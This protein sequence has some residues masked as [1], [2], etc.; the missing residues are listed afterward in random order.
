M[1]EFVKDFDVEIYNEIINEVE[2]NIWNERCISIIQSEIEKIIKNL[3]KENNIVITNTDKDGVVYREYNPTLSRLLNEEESFRGFLFENNILKENDIDDYWIIHRN[4][5]IKKHGARTGEKIIINNEM[6]ES[7]LKFLFKLCFN[8]YNYKFHKTPS[9]YWDER[10]FEKL[11]TK[12]EEKTIEVEKIIEKEIKVVDDVELNK[13]KKEHDELKHKFDTMQK[14]TIPHTTNFELVN[15]LEIA[16]K[17]LQNEDFENAKIA[18]NNCR[19]LDISCI[20]AYIGLIMCDYKQNN[21]ENLAYDI[22]FYKNA[23]PLKENENYIN[24]SNFCDKKLVEKFNKDIEETIHYVKFEKPHQK[25]LSEYDNKEYLLAYRDFQFIHEYKDASDKSKELL[26]ILEQDAKKYEKDKWY[27]RAIIEYNSLQFYT[28]EKE[29]RDY[30]E[31]RINEIKENKKS[32]EETLIVNEKFRSFLDSK[33][34][35][36]YGSNRLSKVKTLIIMEGVNDIFENTFREFS[37]LETII[38]PDSLK[39]IHKN[40]FYY[41]CGKL[42]YNIKNGYKYLGSENN[43]YKILI[44]AENFNV[45]LLAETTEIIAD[46]AIISENLKEL[47]IPKSI[48]Y[49]CDEAFELAP[50]IEKVVVNHEMGTL[51]GFSG[52]KKLKKI[53]LNAPVDEIGDYAFLGCDLLN[54]F[55][56]FKNWHISISNG[57]FKNCI[58]LKSIDFSKIDSVYLGK[59]AFSH[60]DNLENIKFNQVGKIDLSD[61]VFEKCINLKNLVFDQ[62]TDFGMACFSD[63]KGLTEVVLNGCFYFRSGN[64]LFSRC[65]NLKRVFINNTNAKDQSIPYDCFEDCVNLEKITVIGS[66]ISIGGGAFENCNNL[67]DIEIQ[68][69]QYIREIGA[70]AFQ[71]CENLKNSLILN[72]IENIE[73]YAFANSGIEKIEI[74][75]NRIKKIDNWAFEECKNLKEFIFPSSSN[76][77]T[78]IESGLFKSCTALENIKI[79][80]YIVEIDSYAFSDCKNLKNIILPN[81]LVEIGHGA[82]E[83]CIALEKIEIPNDIEKLD[84]CCFSGCKNLKEINIPK[85]IRSLNGA[86]F[87]ECINLEQI[88]IPKNVLKIDTYVFKNCLKLKQIIIETDDDYDGAIF[89]LGKIFDITSISGCESLQHL[90]LPGCFSKIVS[91]ST[92]SQFGTYHFQTLIINKKNGYSDGHYKFN[93]PDN[94]YNLY[95]KQNE[96][97]RF[98]FK[99]K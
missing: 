65:E 3:F 48:K 81:K 51:G 53:E 34:F 40:A 63:C 25:A 31:S 70:H 66:I 22:D 27:E 96:D 89:G 67:K 79:P 97:N 64:C 10:Y 38:L 90:E 23:K 32:E 19:T 15:K 42:K 78:K 1:F 61:F 57:A 94:F 68:N 83:N 87:S 60:C 36:S 69:L 93:L 95:E 73:A 26:S 28:K 58:N 29:L 99:R 16:N 35:S 43:P 17:C 52:C 45:S 75:S 7:A 86:L 44:K 59:Y 80:N 13:L 84:D 91:N 54:D 56:A 72:N 21:M 76:K 12:P 92:F 71:N 49:I 11:L 20:D 88:F 8:V 41:G 37:N 2:F 46:K 39:E 85:G 82:F 33:Y 5:N 6:K 62:I 14:S 9:A 77:L 47:E 18:F 50:N 74:N 4:A 30:I 24:M 55:T 98:V